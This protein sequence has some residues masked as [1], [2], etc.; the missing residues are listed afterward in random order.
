MEDAGE[1]F[2]E[3]V[4]AGH[5]E[6]FATG[7]TRKRFMYGLKSAKEAIARVFGTL[8]DEAGAGE[9]ARAVKKPKHDYDK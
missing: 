8:P 6:E 5:Q 3:M 1:S 4:R 2:S 9:A 7:E